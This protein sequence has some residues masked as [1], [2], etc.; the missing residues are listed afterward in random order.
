MN[1]ID[2]TQSDSGEISIESNGLHP[3]QAVHISSSPAKAYSQSKTLRRKRSSANASLTSRPSLLSLRDH[4]FPISKAQ[5]SPTLNGKV[6]HSGFLG[7]S[8]SSPF[9]L[10]PAAK[11]ENSMEMEIQKSMTTLTLDHDQGI[12]PYFDSS[13]PRDFRSESVFSSSATESETSITLSEVSST[14]SSS[15]RPSWEVED[16]DEEDQS[17]VSMSEGIEQNRLILAHVITTYDEDDKVIN[18]TL[19]HAL[20]TPNLLITKDAQIMQIQ[21]LNEWIKLRSTVE[22]S[23]IVAMCD[24]E[25]KRTFEIHAGKPKEKKFISTFYLQADMNACEMDRSSSNNTKLLKFIIHGLGEEGKNNNNNSNFDDSRW[26]ILPDQIR[27]LLLQ[28]QQIEQNLSEAGHQEN[29]STISNPD[30]KICAK[31]LQFLSEK[32]VREK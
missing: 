10:T 13:G 11:G 22:Q 7:L 16:E 9:T 28:T 2:L 32:E 24:G 14:P 30:A 18:E 20:I 1:H 12:L 27:F 23:R 21:D 29:T 15:R 31:I 6:G 17:N 26:K 8:P 19:G 4:R 3:L 25:E 5:I